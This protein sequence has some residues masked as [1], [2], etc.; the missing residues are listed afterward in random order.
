MLFSIEEQL[1]PS[2]KVKFLIKDG[3]LLLK[4]L[5]PILVTLAG[6][7]MVLYWLYALGLSKNSSVKPVKIVESFGS[8]L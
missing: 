1:D 2:A 8:Y 7:C 5:S 4:A 6:I 3:I